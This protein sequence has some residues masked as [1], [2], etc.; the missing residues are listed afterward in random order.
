MNSQ[1]PG[2]FLNFF[3]DAA[4]SGALSDSQNFWK[5]SFDWFA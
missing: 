5:P 3:G 2:W 1:E 4:K